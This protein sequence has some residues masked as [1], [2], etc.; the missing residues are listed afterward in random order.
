[1]LVPVTRTVF[2][3]ADVTTAIL[4]LAKGPKPDSGLS[5]P[6]PKDC[7]LLGVT[8]KNGVVT[9]NFTKEF[10]EAAE[11]ENGVQSLR[12]IL[13]TAA[14]FPGVKQVKIAVEGKEYQP[15]EQ[16]ESTF[17][18]QDSEIMVYYPGVIEID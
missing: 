3:D 8:M 11:G 10:M 18:N 16:A 7:G 12:A 15:P 17:I 2:S 9:I 13:F 6:L 1:M 4:E 14:Q 5:S